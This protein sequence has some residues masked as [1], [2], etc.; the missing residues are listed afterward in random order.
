[1]SIEEPLIVDPSDQGNKVNGPGAPA[2]NI[3]CGQDKSSMERILS[4]PTVGVM[5]SR[6][7]RAGVLA[8]TSS[9]ALVTGRGFGANIY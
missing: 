5:W 9:P 4:G 3:H 7:M 1:M 2:A 8:G 6:W